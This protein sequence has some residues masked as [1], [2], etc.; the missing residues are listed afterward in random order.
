MAH[1]INELDYSLRLS[2]YNHCIHFPI[3]VTGIVDTFVV[4]ISNPIEYR[5]AKSLFNP[6]YGGFVLKWQVI[7]DFIGNYLFLSGPHVLYDGIIFERT[8]M[9]HPMNPWEL[10]LGDGHYIKL[11]QVLTP[12]RRHHVLS[13][14]E[15]IFNSILSF[16][17]ARVEH[18][19]RRV[20]AHSMFDQVYRGSWEVIDWAIKVI[21]HT[22][23][24]ECRFRPKYAFVGPWWHN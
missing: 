11:D 13:K 20:K 6:K 5:V 9:D 21:V 2:P 7:V 23:N 14:Q 10:L 22:T 19:I 8:L 3:R 12:F 17:R 18:C 16:Y 4:H 15:I 1:C 24:V